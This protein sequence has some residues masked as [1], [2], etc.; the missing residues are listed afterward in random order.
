MLVYVY[1]GKDVDARYAVE[2]LKA[3]RD[4]RVLVGARFFDCVRVAEDTKA[5]RLL[6]IRPNGEVTATLKKPSADKVYATMRA[7]LKKD[8][9]NKLGETVTAQRAILRERAKL[10]RQKKTKEL[11]ALAK[12][13]AALYELKKKKKKKPA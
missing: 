1:N 4:E 3:F 7:V 13:E 2:E 11:E 10:E 8:Y 9:E 5:P 6:L 12:R